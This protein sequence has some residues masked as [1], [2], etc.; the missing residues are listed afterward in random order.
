MHLFPFSV[1]SFLDVKKA[2]IYCWVAKFQIFRPLCWKKKRSNNYQG[3]FNIPVVENTCLKPFRI[4][5]YHFLSHILLTERLRGQ[6][7]RVARLW[8]RK[9]L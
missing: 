1:L 8:C 7:A 2:P 9:L 6:V 3:V 4:G 5:E